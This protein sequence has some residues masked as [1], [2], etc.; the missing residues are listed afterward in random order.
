M[1]ACAC[2]ACNQCASHQ[3]PRNH[4]ACHQHGSTPHVT[5]VHHTSQPT[6]ITAAITVH[7]TSQPTTIT[8]AITPDQINTRSIR[9]T[10]HKSPL[11]T[12]I[13][14]QKIHRTHRTTQRPMRAWH[15]RRS[16]VLTR[17]HRSQAGIVLALFEQ[18]PSTLVVTR[19]TLPLPPPHIISHT[20]TVHT[21]MPLHTLLSSRILSALLV[22]LCEDLVRAADRASEEKVGGSPFAR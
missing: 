9:I 22:C 20:H 2:T 6:T 8:A 4:T 1:P 13:A 7:H 21:V 10:Q 12:R 14:A 18:P 5:K 17:P 15:G 19:H 11:G 3:S 16:F